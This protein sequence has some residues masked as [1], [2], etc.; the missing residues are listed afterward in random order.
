MENLPS[1]A[2]HVNILVI[3]SIIDQ[4]N[5]LLP[6]P[7]PGTSYNFRHSEIYNSS[8]VK[9]VMFLMYSILM[10]MQQNAGIYLLYTIPIQRYKVHP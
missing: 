4:M 2:E 10:L 1:S 8:L 9:K 5:M 7:F 6:K 3:S